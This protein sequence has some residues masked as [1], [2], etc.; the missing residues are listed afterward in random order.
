VGANAGYG[1]GRDATTQSFAGVPSDLFAITPV[2]WLGG[3]Q[4][5]YNFQAANNWVLGVEGDWQW[6]GQ[7]DVGLIR[8]FPITPGFT[9]QNIQQKLPWFATIRGRVGYAAG[10]VLYYATAGVAFTDLQSS[11]SESQPA[12]YS[13][14]FDNH[15]TGFAAGGGIEAALGGNWTAKAEY[16]Y[17]DFG[18]VTILEAPVSLASIS[19]DMHDHVF[20]LGVNYGWGGH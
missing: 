15:R 16:L 8:D 4:L 14:A 12:S 13:A 19:G 10:P 5:G 18:N 3:V 7:K 20:R 2:G 11:Y 6:T 9:N 1:I 17:L